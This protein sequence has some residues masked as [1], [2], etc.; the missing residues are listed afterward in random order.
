MNEEFAFDIAPLPGSNQFAMS[1]QNRVQWTLNLVLPELDEPKQFWVVWKEVV[2]L[3]NEL[4]EH[5]T[6][7]GQSV[8][9][10]SQRETVALE[11]QLGC[12]RNTTFVKILSWSLHNRPPV[13]DE[14]LADISIGVTLRYEKLVRCIDLNSS[15]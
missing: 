2:F 1:E 12:V 7:I 11:H 6:V 10:P 4:V 14:R 3:P 13:L 8:E 15:E 5:R 9:Q